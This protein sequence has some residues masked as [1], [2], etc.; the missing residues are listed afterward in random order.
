M[1]CAQVPPSASFGTLGQGTAAGSSIEVAFSPEGGAET[2]VLKVIAS[3]RKST[4]LADYSFTSPAVV[5]ALMEAK[6][7]GVDVK[8][9]IDDKGNRGKT[10]LAAMNLIM[11]AGPPLRVV[12]SYAIDHDKCIMVDGRHTETDPCQ[13]ESVDSHHGCYRILQNALP[14]RGIASS[15]Q[16]VERLRPALLRFRVHLL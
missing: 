16:A 7:R 4:W 6:R 13:S 12:S 9:L 10:S 3:D 8:V 2:L 14:V 5:K 1:G 15:I 11:G